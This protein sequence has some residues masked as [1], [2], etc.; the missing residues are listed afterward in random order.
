M[1]TGQPSQRLI[2]GHIGYPPME[3]FTMEPFNTVPIRACPAFLA[4]RRCMAS[5]VSA[6]RRTP[7]REGPVGRSAMAAVVLGHGRH[8][9]LGGS[10]ATL[11]TPKLW[12][13][14][15]HK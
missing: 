8:L 2:N 1:Q 13:V 6:F 12:L 5:Q 15:W 9:F 3:F 11:G 4:M 7:G 10:Q 14:W